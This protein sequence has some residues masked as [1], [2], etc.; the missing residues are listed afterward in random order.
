MIPTTPKREKRNADE[1]GALAPA[2]AQH[3]NAHTYS[4]YLRT[5]EKLGSDGGDLLFLGDTTQTRLVREITRKHILG[6]TLGYVQCCYDAHDKT[7]VWVIGLVETKTYM[8]PIVGTG[9]HFNEKHRA[10]VWDST[11]M[12]FMR[13]TEEGRE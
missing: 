13:M 6:Y 1:G 11:D 9:Y 5:C 4:V 8:H 2:Q 7:T 10:Y 3:T 12:E